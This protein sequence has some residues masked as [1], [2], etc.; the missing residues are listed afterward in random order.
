MNIK[1]QISDI[2]IRD[3]FFDAL[4]DIAAKDSDV[5]F[6][7]ADTGAF[8]LDRFKKDL[9]SQYIN[10]G[11]AEQ[12]LVSVAAGL[13]LG[14][15]KVFIYAIAPFI[16]QRCYEQIKIDI[17]CMRL[18][19]TIIGVGA[20]ITYS[21]DGPTHQATQDIAIMRA[22]P[23][24][25]ILNP[26]DPVSAA[27]A[28]AMAY[29]SNGPVYVRVDKGKLPLLYSNEDSFSEGLAV[30][31]D[32]RDVLILT[33]GIMVHQAYKVTDELAERSI[34]AGIVDIY[35]IK[36]INEKLLLGIID[37]Y[38]RIVTL[39]ENSII[40]GIA[41]TVGEILIDNQK[42][43][44]LKPIALADAYCQGYGNREWMHS[45]YGL[46]V[47]SITSTILN[48]VQNGC[49]P[50]P[51]QADRWASA[52][53]AGDYDQRELTVKNFAYLI[54]TSVD[55]IPA[56]C[57]H[58]LSCHDFRY[59]VLTGHAHDAMLVDVL[60]KIDSGKLSVTGKEKQ[61]VWESGWSENLQDF[62]ANGYNIEDLV[63]K[64]YRPGQPLRI[65]RT[66]ARGYAPCFEYN[67]F[68]VLRT[69][70]Y[71]KYLKDAGSVYEFGCGPGHN[72]VALAKQH[73]E[74]NLYGFDWARSSVE[75]VNKI[76][77]VYKLN[78]TGRLFDM[79]SP[80]DSVQFADSSAVIT[81][82]AL[83]QLGD[84]YGAFLQFLLRKAPAQCV[85][86]EPLCELYDENELLD[87][88]A[89]KHHKKRNLLGNLLESLRQLESRGK[90][91]IVKI[92]RVLVGGL[93]EDGWSY[94]VWKPI[95]AVT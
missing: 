4:Y 86:V 91:E 85:H 10:V 56:E 15:K 28:A 46:D 77:D 95:R 9:S 90:I 41:S 59:E 22:L 74:K 13:T 58:L 3:A 75:L 73:P 30:L 82:G 5:M 80:D 40:G 71:T 37:R 23:G 81:M 25:T 93:L 39:E 35:R 79:F 88:I 48:W 21:S 61:P 38:E 2:D 62:I 42:A 52:E 36:P 27:A 94:V 64:Y 84:N 51:V 14:G 26:S 32:G 6:L 11:V 43:V 87:Y 92:Q 89:I 20:G 66:Y 45:A 7:T 34:D 70:I 29:K 49:A 18:P 44:A 53:P 19:V 78:I 12:N 47:E 68:K 16:T 8:S 60:K 63:P 17:S 50:I 31:K 33:T 55:D 57:Q 83:E 65:D 72:L 1:S 67:F 69:W 24:M 76:A 54:G